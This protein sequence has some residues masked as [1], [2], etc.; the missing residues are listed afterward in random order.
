MTFR[1]QQANDVVVMVADGQL[2]DARYERLRVTDRLGA[3][4][5]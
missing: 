3:V 1:V 2:S 4:W 5:R